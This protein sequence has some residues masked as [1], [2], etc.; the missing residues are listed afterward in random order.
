MPEEPETEIL[1]CPRCCRPFPNVNALSFHLNRFRDTP[2][3]TSCELADKAANAMRRA[4]KV[5]K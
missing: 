4:P 3:M 2:K 1:L 5:E